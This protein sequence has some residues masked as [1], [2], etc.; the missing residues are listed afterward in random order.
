M[1]SIG[2]GLSSLFKSIAPKDARALRIAESNERYRQAVVATWHE[3][4]AAADF[5]LKSTCSLYLKR[6]DAPRKAAPAGADAR[7]PLVMGVYLNDSMAR[8][9]LNARRE[10]LRLALAQ[11]GTRVDEI[12]IHPATGN[13]RQRRVFP[14]GIAGK[15]GA[16]QAASQPSG[17]RPADASTAV[18]APGRSGA[19]AHD[20]FTDADPKA[21]RRVDQSNLLEQLKRAFCMSFDDLGKAEALL[22]RVEGAFMQE[23]RVGR[24]RTV[25]T[26]YR[27]HLYVAPEDLGHMKAAIGY[28]EAT[29]LSQAKRIGLRL[30]A[31]AVYES[32]AELRGHCAFPAQ[33]A[34]VAVGNIEAARARREAERVRAASIDQAQAVRRHVRGR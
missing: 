5:L 20:A 10:V 33:G 29:V 25:R 9:E 14:E 16:L 11:V 26:A 30:S 13:M 31:I 7:P 1:Q 17:R 28:C 22:A 3:N 2:T 6:D 19:G 15:D 12:V 4:P 21:N 24:G 23:G 18:S 34:P 27:C 8:S 32:S